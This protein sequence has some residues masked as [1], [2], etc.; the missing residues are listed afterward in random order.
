MLIQEAD[1]W[2]EIA[3]GVCLLQKAGSK[4]LAMGYNVGQP[5]SAFDNSFALNH[6]LPATMPEVVGKTLWGRATDGD[7]SVA[8]ELI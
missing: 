5:D 8:I 3:T 7:V 6:N 2:V 1:G 4:T